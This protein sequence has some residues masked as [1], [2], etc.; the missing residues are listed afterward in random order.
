MKGRIVMAAL[1]LPALLAGCGSANGLKPPAS[2]AAA[3]KPYGATRTPTP[4][5]LLTPSN[6]ARTERSDELLKKSERRR[7]DDFDLP[8][9]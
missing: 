6:Q 1:L 8:P 9:S 5:E 2:A 7:G 4:T 3:A